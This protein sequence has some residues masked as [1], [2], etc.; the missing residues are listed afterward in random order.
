MKTV[1]LKGF[2]RSSS[3]LGQVNIRRL[4][5]HRLGRFDHDGVCSVA[6]ALLLQHTNADPCSR[7]HSKVVLACL[8]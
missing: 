4:G 5:L 2:P 8:A 6:K 3:G 7:R 1:L